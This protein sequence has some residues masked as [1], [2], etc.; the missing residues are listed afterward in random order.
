MRPADRASSDSDGPGQASP[1]R[2]VF[3]IIKENRTYDQVFGDLRQGNGDPS[4]V[5]FGRDVTPNHHALAEQ[6]VLLDNYYAPGDQSALGHRWCTQGYASDWLHKYGNGR[7]DAN[8][9]LFAPTDFLWDNAKAH[10]LS[11][12]A[13]GERG[14]QY[15]HARRI[16]LDGRSTTTGRAA[17]ARSASLRGRWCS[18]CATSTI[19]ATPAFDMKVTDQLRVDEFLK[20]FREFEKNGNLPRLVVM[21]LPQDHTAGTSPGYPTPRAC[22]ADNDLAL[23]RLVEAISQQPVL[24]GIRH[25]RH[26]GRR[27]E[28]PGPRGRPPHGRP[29]DQPLGA[30]QGRGQH[31]LH[32][33]QHVPHHRADPGAAAVEPVRPGRRAD[34]P[35]VHRTAGFLAVQG[36]CQSESRSTR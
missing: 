32:D 29:G 5:Q 1:I 6:Y 21:L 23:G 16:R 7:N 30:A 11:V 24:E 26:R 13:Y 12:R 27:A 25:F 28:R 2:H 10:G 20:E 9:M 36:A 4:L 34:V 15:H 17:R 19:R 31:V 33:H 14:Q 22:V 35:G 8:P 3:Y 18:G